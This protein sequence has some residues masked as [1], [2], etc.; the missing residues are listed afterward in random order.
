MTDLTVIGFLPSPGSSLA[1]ARS[2]LDAAAKSAGANAVRHWNGGAA[3]SYAVFE[4]LESPWVFGGA[5]AEVEI[6][7][8][9]ELIVEP[10]G[11]LPAAVNRDLDLNDSGEFTAVY[12]CGKCGG[13][14]P[15]GHEPGCPDGG[16]VGR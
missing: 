1:A 7:G 6:V 15:G 8:R 14:V 10:V 9:A 11:E 2:A 12:L 13:S 4:S 3:A 16:A 5:V